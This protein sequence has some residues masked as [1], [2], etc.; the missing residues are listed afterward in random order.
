MEL[1][2]FSLFK[3]NCE[4]ESVL[5]VSDLKVFAAVAAEICPN[6]RVKRRGASSGLNKAFSNILRS[7]R[8]G[9]QRAGENFF[10]FK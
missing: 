6:D 9:W 2:V 3:A 7:M 5:D 8:G 1:L 4:L 10:P